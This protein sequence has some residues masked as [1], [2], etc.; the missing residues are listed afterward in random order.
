MNFIISYDLNKDDKNY[1]GLIE[2]IKEI[3]TGIWCSPCKSTWVINSSLR[4]SREAYE[5]LATE[6]DDN[7]YI[8][9]VEITTNIYGL[10]HKD[11]ADF[12]SKHFMS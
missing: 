7:D 9:I 12:L 6:I 2:K 11:N 3:S 10:M 1:D 8:I 5:K 4:S